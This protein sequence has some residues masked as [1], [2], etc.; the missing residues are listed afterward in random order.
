MKPYSQPAGVEL[1]VAIEVHDR[2]AARERPEFAR[3]ALVIRYD[4]AD[5]R[6]DGRADDERVG[7]RQPVGSTETGGLLGNMQVDWE[8][9]DEETD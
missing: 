7:R 4:V 9:A 2:H 8:G 1:Q 3:P 5:L 6:H